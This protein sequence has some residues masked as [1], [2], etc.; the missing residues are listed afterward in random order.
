VLI[1]LD[2]FDQIKDK[3]GLGSQ[4]KSL[5]SPTVKYCP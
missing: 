4:I 2:E 3:T 1:L 5:T